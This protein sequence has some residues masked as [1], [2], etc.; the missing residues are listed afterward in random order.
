M[1]TYMYMNMCKMKTFFKTEKKNNEKNK[2]LC[3]ILVCVRLMDNLRNCSNA[4][5]KSYK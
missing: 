5:C 3:C 4:I 1:H 2:T